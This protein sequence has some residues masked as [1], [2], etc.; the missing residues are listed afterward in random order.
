MHRRQLFRIALS[1]LLFAGAGT[2]GLIFLL[3]AGFQRLS[4]SQFVGL[5]NANADFLRAA[6]L[7]KSERLAGYMSQL[8]GM[9]VRFE[10]APATDAAHES[11]TV[12]V[13]PGLDLTLIRERPTLKALL[14]RPVTIVALAVFWMLWF[15]LAWAVAV[16]YFRTQ[17][18]AILGGMATSLAHEIRNPVNA[19]RLHG[20]LL[21]DAEPGPAGLI[22]NEASRIEDIVNQWMFLA[23]PAPP[24]RDELAVAGLLEQTVQLLLPALQHARVKIRI[25]AAPD[26]IIRADRRRLEQVFHNIIRNAIQAMPAGGSLTITARDGLISFADTGTGFSARALRRW[27]E[28]L[29]SEREG[30]MGIG[31]NVADSIVRAHGGRLAVANRPEGGAVV[32]IAL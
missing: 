20:Q 27:K 11:V 19:I 1:F 5:A 26:W 24:C 15:A 9:E 3:N 32:C 23:R 4:N 12:P 18:L 7:P 22:V 28:M 25:D 17:R 6:N 10:S 14:C 21:Q 31:L 2:V 30:G 8:L 13:K 16:P 29:Y